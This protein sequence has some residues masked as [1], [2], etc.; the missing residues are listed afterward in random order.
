MNL[1]DIPPDVLSEALRKQYDPNDLLELMEA[2]SDTVLYYMWDEIEKLVSR[3][4]EDLKDVVEQHCAVGDLDEF[5]E[6]EE[7]Q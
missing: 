7:D 3:G 5:I 2:D 6:E 1:H 4:S